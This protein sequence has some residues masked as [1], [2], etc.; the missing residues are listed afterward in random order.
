M[1]LCVGVHTA[2]LPSPNSSCNLLQSVDFPHPPFPLMKQPLLS[3]NLNSS[4]FFNTFFSGFSWIK[5][6]VLGIAGS[7]KSTLCNKLQEELGE[8]KYAV[9]A[10]THKAA[11]LIG[12]VTVYNL[13]NIDTHTHTYLKSAVEKLKN[14]GV[15]WIFIDEISM[16]NSKIWGVLS[17]IK[18]KI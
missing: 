6:L 16:I 18:K 8:G 12:A 4:I 15:E 17:D 2:Y 1:L 11:L 9:C 5:F 14:S 10:P 7:G 13:F 3:C